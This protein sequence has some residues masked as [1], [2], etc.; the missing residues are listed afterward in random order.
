MAAVADRSNL[1]IALGAVTGAFAWT[2]TEYA[3]HRWVLHGPFGKGRLKHLPLGR[4]HRAHHRAPDVTSFVARSAGHV[5]IAAGAA[6]AAD[7][8][9]L[10]PD[11]AAARDGATSA[12]RQAVGHGQLN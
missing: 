6:A 3:T 5:A 1:H 4:L 9:H 10:G 7:D 8:A 11:D 12:G 2:A